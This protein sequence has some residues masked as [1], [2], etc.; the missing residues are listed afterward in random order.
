MMA[1]GFLAMAIAVM[2]LWPET[3]AAIWLHRHCVAC[4]LEWAERA[5]RRQLLTSLI[6]LVMILSLGELAMLAPMD[7][8]A[9]V[10]ADTATY[11]DT[12]IAVWTVT[13]IMRVKGAGR[14]LIARLPLRRGLRLG[15]RT[16]RRRVR[17]MAQ[18]K[19]SNDD[20]G[21][22]ALAVAA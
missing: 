5:T 9:L 1:I 2:K 8:L 4:P 3:R 22:P 13:A 16:R 6:L 15:T 18:R 19:P 12:L 17:P 20:E 10:A 11:V 21:D 7:M 14:A